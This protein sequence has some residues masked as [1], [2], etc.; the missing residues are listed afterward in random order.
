MFKKILNYKSSGS[1]V[2]I[3]AVLLVAAIITI[4]AVSSLPSKS[5]AE[6]NKASAENGETGGDAKNFLNV[7]GNG[8]VTVEP[9][10][11]YI[12]LGVVTE[13]ENAVMAQKDNA[14]A[15]D[16][17]IADIV[18][19]GI[20]EEDIKTTNYSIYPK[21]NYIKE[22]GEQKIIG[23]TVNNSV[24]ATIRDTSK[25][26]EII[27]LASESGLNI[28]SGISFG[29]SNYD[30]Y[31]C[32][33]L[34]N[35]VENAKKKAETMAEAFGIV[36]GIPV[37]MTESG[38]YSP[39]PVYYDRWDEYAAVGNASVSTPIQSGTIEVNASVGITYEY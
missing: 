31:Y 6:V 20:K 32:E 3:I 27:D 30:E 9:D 23:Y 38:G 21:Y 8:R 14:A 16:R 34:K 4:I 17:I 7:Y 18:A 37:S 1:M 19:A 22:T 36:L 39:A 25:V 11:A 24:Q 29:L 35:A 12:T 5:F 28:T 2:F 13:N 26:G 33:A 10:I 15:M